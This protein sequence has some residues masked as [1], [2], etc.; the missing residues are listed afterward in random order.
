MNGFKQH[1]PNF[2][3]V[4]NDPIWIPF[5]TVNDL[6]NIEIVKRYGRGKKFSHFAV[7]DNRL[8]EISDDGFIWWVVGYIKYPDKI[9]LKKWDGPKYHARLTNGESVILR[10]EVVSSCG[11][12][13]TLTDGSTAIN[14]EYFAK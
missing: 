6:L 12:I 3:T 8:M 14:I 7:L 1:I 4:D 9:N 2:V 11:D 5:E 10:K 13:L